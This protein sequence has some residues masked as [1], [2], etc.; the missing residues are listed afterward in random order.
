MSQPLTE[1]SLTLKRPD[2]AEIHYRLTRGDGLRPVLVLIHGMASNLTRWWEFIENTGLASSWD[3]LR[4]DLR[5]HGGS[6]F[7]GRVGMEVWCGDLNAILAAEGYPRAVIAGHC[8]GANIAVFYAAHDPER[9]AGL[10]LIEP[11]PREGLAGALKRIQPIK[12]LAKIIV[13]I[14][15]ILNGLG[16][17]RRRLPRLD[18]KKLDMTTRE[19]IARGGSHE[20]MTKRY[21]NP[22]ADLRFLPRAVY[23]QEFIELSRLLPPLSK[24]KAPV[25]SLISSG[26]FI[27]DPAI[28][29]RILEGLPN[30]RIIEMPAR[31]WIPTECP[32]Q[33][34]TEIETWCRGLKDM[35]P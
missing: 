24:I 12:P 32:D 11:M 15:R 26:R 33:M 16:I 3:I 8:L 30:G 34:R 28:N 9:T 7:R 2:G 31:H 17:Y 10:I 27:S 22:W 1:Q 14:I 35:E 23:L 20:T 5:G 6:P 4:M 21:S 25:L 29:R 18:L 13:G 19:T